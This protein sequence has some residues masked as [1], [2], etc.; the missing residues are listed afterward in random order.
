[1]ARRAYI[2]LGRLAE[3]PPEELKVEWG[4]RVCFFPPPPPLPVSRPSCCGSG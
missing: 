2:T 3:L 4:G 1:M